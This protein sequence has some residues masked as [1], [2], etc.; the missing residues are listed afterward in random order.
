MSPNKHGDAATRELQERAK[1]EFTEADREILKRY[2]AVAESVARIFGSGCE[3]VLHSLEDMAHSV[4]KIVNGQVTGRSPGSP[5]TDLGLDVLAKSFESEEDI[6]GPYFSN[7]K[8]GKP[9]KSVTTLIRN[10][11]GHPI[12][13]L[14]INYDLSVPLHVFLRE[15]SPS[16]EAPEAGEHFAPDVGELVTQAVFDELETISRVN[17]VSS[18]EKNRRVVANLETRGVFEIKGSVE[19]VAGQLG[20][21]RHTIYKYLRGLRREK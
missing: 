10:R 15:F 21:T 13:F 5:I 11:E 9:L 17:G 2:E 3:V 1:I 19:L 8:A 7:T 20:V 4:V 16:R 12:G 14:C 18:T 6:I